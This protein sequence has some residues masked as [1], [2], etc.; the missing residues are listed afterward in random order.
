MACRHYYAIHSGHESAFSVDTSII[1]YGPRVI[2][3]VGEHAKALKMSRVA[4]F[5]DR[6]VRSLQCVA[7]ALQALKDAKIEVEIFADVH[8]EPTDASVLDAARFAVSGSFDGYVS[9]GGGSVIDTCK[10]A[11]L[12]ATYPENLLHY[13]RPPIGAGSPIPGPLEPHIACPTTCGTGTEATAAAVFKYLP[14]S[15]KLIVSGKVMKP[16]L[17]LIDPTTTYSLPKPV[18]AASGFD[19]LSHAIESYTARPYTRPVRPASTF[20][21]PYLQGAN[22]WSDIGCEAA[23]K[24]MGKY[25]V[26]AYNDPGDHEARDAMIFAAAMAGTALGNAGTQ[27]PHGM[28]YAVSG[29]N[30]SF[31][32]E[33][34]ATDAPIIPHGMSVIVNA[35][36]AFRFS[37]SACPDRHLEC[38]RFLGADTKGAELEDAG[39]ILAATVV[40]LMKA[41]GI[42]NGLQAMGY[43]EGDA[44]RLAEGVFSYQQR[45]I[46]LAPREVTKE[47]LKDLFRGSMTCWSQA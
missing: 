33:G 8:V 39:E 29:Y 6:T 42:P 11:N 43:Q 25:F 26:R 7:D 47:N 1:S 12:L 37:A 22:P 15:M 27:L 41:T 44:D 31:R 5:T 19:V 28:S 35:P 24:K 36:A 14:L 40:Q 46:G 4:L 45:L 17:G 23:L 9:V 21:R 2:L 34:Y 13:M 38:A 16:S 20:H 10:I 32:C 18:V 30:K 3:E